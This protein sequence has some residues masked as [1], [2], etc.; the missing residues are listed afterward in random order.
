MSIVD[1]I[2][3]MLTRIRNA[4]L[5]SAPEVCIEASKMKLSVLSILKE[6]GFVGDSKMDGN[7]ICIELKYED[8]EP[9]VR[10]IERVSKPGRRVYV[11]NTEIP[12]VLSGHG[13]AVISTSKGMMTGKQAREEH[14]GGELICKLY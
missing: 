14:L 5:V 7:K 6:N 4:Y 3:D 12:S 2:S 8:G 10:S 9:V 1:P 13:V 11:K